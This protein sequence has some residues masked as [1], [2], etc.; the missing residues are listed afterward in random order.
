LGIKAYSLAALFKCLLEPPIFE[1]SFGLAE[2]LPL[3]LNLVGLLV[4]RGR[5]IGRLR[6]ALRVRLAAA[7]RRG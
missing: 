1:F 4:G 7:S 3:S 6:P 5:S 2:N